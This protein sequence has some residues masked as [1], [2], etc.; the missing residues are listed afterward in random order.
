MDLGTGMG[1]VGMHGHTTGSMGAPPITSSSGGGREHQNSQQYLT[2]PEVVVRQIRWAAT[3]AGDTHYAPCPAY[4]YYDANSQASFEC[5]LPAITG[6]PPHPTGASAPGAL[7]SVMP[8][9]AGSGPNLSRC[10]SNWVRDIHQRLQ[11]GDSLPA[12]AAELS[13]RTRP[14]PPSTQ[15]HHQQQQPHPLFGEDLIQL[16]QIVQLLVQRMDVLLDNISDD[17]QRLVFVREL[18]QVSPA[19]IPSSARIPPPLGSIP[20]RVPESTMEMLP[21]NAPNEQQNGHV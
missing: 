7:G 8:H 11:S 12:I 20:S 13:Q 4:A 10:I 14:L 2:C 19:R 6:P 21:E 15:H 9:W 16:G 1:V 18:V 3:R 5:V 17:K